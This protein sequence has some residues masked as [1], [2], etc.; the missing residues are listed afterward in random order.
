MCV[1]TA[2]AHPNARG[3]ARNRRQAALPSS[4]GTDTAVD[5]HST[6][7][8]PSHPPAP[9]TRGTGRSTAAAAESRLLTRA[10]TAADADKNQYRR[11]AELG[12]PVSLYYYF[13]PPRD[14]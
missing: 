1:G 14:P 6:V 5:S 9:P 4:K 13:V 3:S 2:R 8:R 7:A 10:A 11:E 12:V